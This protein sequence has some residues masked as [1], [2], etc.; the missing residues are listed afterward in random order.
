MLSQ[1]TFLENQLVGFVLILKG[2]TSLPLAI[3]TPF[4]GNLNL[5]G[6]NFEKGLKQVLRKLFILLL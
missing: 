6:I 1:K 3:K 5:S 4:I 2:G